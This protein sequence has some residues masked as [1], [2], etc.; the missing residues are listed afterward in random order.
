MH[1]FPS[2]ANGNYVVVVVGYTNDVNF[3]FDFTSVSVPGGS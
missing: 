2:V 1:T 3:Q